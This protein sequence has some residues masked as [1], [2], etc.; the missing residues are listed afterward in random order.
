MKPNPTL[1]LT[2]ALTT[3]GA[4]IRDGHPGRRGNQRRAAAAERAV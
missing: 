3:I 1:A 2:M 4:A